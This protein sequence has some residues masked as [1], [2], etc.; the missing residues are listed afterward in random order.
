LG[1][2][3]PLVFT[4]TNTGS[5]SLTLQLLGRTPTADFQVSNPDGQ[6]IWSRLGGKPLVSVL[7]LVPLDAG[8]VLSFRQSW[9]QRTDTGLAVA[10]GNYLIRAV[11]MTDA[12]GGMASS[13]AQVII[14]G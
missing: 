13:P 10:P 8:K 7:R 1:E 11:L 9:N 3:V 14:E 5:S 4:V 12:P 2:P 6:K